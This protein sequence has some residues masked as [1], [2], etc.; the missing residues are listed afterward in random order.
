MGYG[1]TIPL[2]RTRLLEQREWIE[3]LEQLG[4]TDLWSSEA[5]AMDGMTPLALASTWAPSMRLG[6]ACLPVQTR[7]PAT[8]AMT[9]AG[10]AEAAP[11]RVLFGIGASSPA[12]VQLWN[13]IEYRKPLQVT[14]DT[15]RFLQRALAGERVT[16]DF[17]SFSVKF[18]KLGVDVQEPPKLFVAALRE[19]MLR[20]ASEEADGVILNMVTP[21]DLD[22]V[23]SI[24]KSSGREVEIAVRV[25][26]TPSSDVERA[27]AVAREFAKIYF[28]VPTYSGHQKWLGRGPLLKEFEERLAKGDVAAA[29]AALPDE[30]VESHWYCGSP[31]ECRSRIQAYFDAGVDTIILSHLEEVADAHEVARE[32]A[33]ARVFRE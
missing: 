24:L 33:P 29:A 13:G 28:A 14:R 2:E 26:I 32:L 23:I 31:D 6:C 9:A 15:L 22:R 21:T 30:V 16:E 8:M 5:R 3:E 11:G 1:M 20:L 4:Y 12:I 25:T 18:Y 17:E 19:K 27:K 7:G 10:I